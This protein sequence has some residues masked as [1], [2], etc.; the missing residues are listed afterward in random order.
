M[1]I[2]RYVQTYYP[3]LHYTDYIALHELHYTML[4]PVR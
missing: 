4:I 2:Q 3:T 1:Q